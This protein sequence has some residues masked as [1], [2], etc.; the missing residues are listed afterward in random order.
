MLDNTDMSIFVYCV[1]QNRKRLKDA[2]LRTVVAPFRHIE[3]SQ[4]FLDRAR[5]TRI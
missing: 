2:S 5:T 1:R 3:A 4:Q